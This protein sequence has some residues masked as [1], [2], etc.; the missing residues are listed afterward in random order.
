MKHKKL[1]L[2][3]LSLFLGLLIIITPFASAENIDPNDDDSQYAYGEN[4]GWLNFKPQV[5]G[6]PGVHVCRLSH[7]FT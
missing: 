1:R 5:Q 2:T 3:L 4:T 6:D 7:Y